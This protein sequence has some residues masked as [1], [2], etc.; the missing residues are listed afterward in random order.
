MGKKNKNISESGG[1]KT[2]EPF[3][4]LGTLF[5]SVSQE[6][7]KQH[8]LLLVVACILMKFVVV[9]FTTAVFH[10]FI[11]YFDIG[12]YFEHA[13]PILQG[14][15]PYI[16]YQIEYPVLAFLPIL[17]AL[18]PA[19]LAQ[20]A[21]VFV[22]SFQFLMVVCDIVT[23][24]CVYLIALKI[25][26]EKRAFLSAIIYVT[27]FSTAYFVIT[28][29]DAFPTCLLML[30]LLFTFYGMKMKGY[31]CAGLGFFAKLFPAIA[32]PFLILHNSKKT[33]L[34]E[35]I[36]AVLKVMVPLSI[37]FLVPVLILRPEAINAYFSAT[38]SGLGV[39]A[40]TLTYTLYCY[41]QD[42]GHLGISIGGISTVM[43]ILMGIVFLF[44]LYS[45]YIDKEKKPV[46]LL[47]LIV[48]ALISAVLFT[49]FHSP[50]YI[51]WFTPLLCLLVADDI[52]KILLFY[53][54]QVFAY[55]EFPLMFG[56]FYTNLQY[57]SAVGSAGWYGTLV[58]FTMEYAAL[59][60]LVYL[61]I[62]PGD[63]IVATL[64]RTFRIEK[65]G[66]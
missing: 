3:S 54:T 63:G 7:V 29:Y 22:L 33:S 23:T 51:V 10:S 15:I 43:Y 39:Y 46:M 26:D 42:I 48:C 58:F 60:L 56:T 64:K 4:I 45:A 13:L 6:T 31:L 24:L 47:M 25:W 1:K 5:D 52:Y 62:R 66:E 18:V 14:Q 12:T 19:V 41:S 55:I 50:Q 53:L 49:K 34:S 28:K 40:N 20:N 2:S 61:I 38:G 11:D 59:L 37:I 30:A 32:F 17:I 9:F 35:E 21:M 27:A 44:L 57:T 65:H 16:N 8:V 36:I